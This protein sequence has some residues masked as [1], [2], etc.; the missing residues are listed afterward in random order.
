MNL[1]IDIGNTRTKLAVFDGKKLLKFVILKQRWSLSKAKL[2]LKKYKIQ[3]V[4][5]TS[6]ANME[7]QLAAYLRKE[8]A[9]LELTDKTAIPINNLYRT[10]KT[11]GK[12]RLAAV[13][14]ATELFPKKASLV[15]DA[16]TCITNDIIDADHNYHGG[17]I[18]PGIEMRFKAMDTFTA[19]LPLVKRRKSDDFMGNTTISC[20]RSGTQWGVIYEMEGFIREYKKKF[21]RIN[22]ILTGGD[23]DFFANRL[24]TKIFVNHYLVHI[25]LNKILNYNVQ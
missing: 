8:Y 17:N 6:V 24:K 5:L 4:A 3:N 21:G 7:Q 25:G 19:R 1:I 20:M 2:F 14:G 9:L 16:G 22:V 11:L 10:P 18:I 15:I 13:V 12:D 23:A